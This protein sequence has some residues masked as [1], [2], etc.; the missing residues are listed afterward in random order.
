MNE[1]VKKMAEIKE[2]KINAE[3]LLETQDKMNKILLQQ[4]NDL[5]NFSEE[6][7][8]FLNRDWNSIFEEKSKF[9][10][11]D[12]KF[13]ILGLRSF[14]FLGEFNEEFSK[15]FLEFKD[16]LG[17]LQLFLSNFYKTRLSSEEIIP[18]LSNLFNYYLKDLKESFI[19]NYSKKVHQIEVQIFQS[20]KNIFKIYEIY[21]GKG[22]TKS[23]K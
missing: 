7:I 10:E 13:F 16:F 4:S 14:D 1:E 5:Q 11:F 8:S 18:I 21:L 17:D 12:K 20:T 19:L 3:D 23:Y 15:K 22:F 9:V 2:M 6:F